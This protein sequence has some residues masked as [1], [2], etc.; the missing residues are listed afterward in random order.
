MNRAVL[1]VGVFADLIE[2]EGMICQRYPHGLVL[3]G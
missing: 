2:E 3:I 1:T